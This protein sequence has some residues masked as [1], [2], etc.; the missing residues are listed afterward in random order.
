MN[1]FP[2][3]KRIKLHACFDSIV[4]LYQSSKESLVHAAVR[5]T[6]GSHNPTVYSTTTA[7]D[8]QVRVIRTK[9]GIV[10]GKEG[11]TL[12]VKWVE[13]LHKEL[14]ATPIAGVTIDAF[15]D[16]IKIE[17]AEKNFI[18][19]ETDDIWNY[20]WD[21][22]IDDEVGEVKLGI[23]GEGLINS[24]IVPDYVL[25][26]IEQAIIAFKSGRNGAALSL[27]SISLESA[28]RDA[29]ITKGYIYQSHIPSQDSY[30]KEKIQVH[31]DTSGFKVIFP[32]PMPQSFSNFLSA[33]TGPTFK[34]YK[35][36]R[37]NLNGTWVLQLSDID[38]LKDYWSSDQINVA[39]QIRIGGLGTALNV[40]R[41][42]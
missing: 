37:V 2:K 30:K 11:Q 23:R 3:I 36:K 12:F 13:E 20:T 34:E 5:A 21:L 29:L 18:K 35:I 16:L 40:A 28:L 14:S 22:E 27:L 7:V 26:N 39:G 33:P 38:D 9:I 10:G 8:N 4:N 19:Y 25:C 24:E 6:V 42:I 41:N 17:Q 1:S 15:L 32:D 31:K